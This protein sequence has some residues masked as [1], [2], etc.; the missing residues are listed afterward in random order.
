MTAGIETL[1]ILGERGV[2]DGLERATGRLAEG[3]RSLAT[4]VQVASVGSMFGLFFADRPVRSWDDARTADADR[5]AAFHRAL[6]ESG[7]YLA[8]SQFE[9]G[10]VST[11]HS[12]EEID[13][14]VK[15]AREALVDL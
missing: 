9:A 15:A 13:A 14:T 4:A 11:A 1:R 5:F 8:P 12:D 6:L 7:V 2:W 10:F 3:L